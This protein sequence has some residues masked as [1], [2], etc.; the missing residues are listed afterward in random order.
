MSH[1]IQQL[2][3]KC[4]A[5]IPSNEFHKLL[6]AKIYG[7]LDELDLQAFK[8]IEAPPSKSKSSRDFV[9]SFQFIA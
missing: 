3:T 8:G 7:L 6:K 5:I 1:S 4:E 9:K 2:K